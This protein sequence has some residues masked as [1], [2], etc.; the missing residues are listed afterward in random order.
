MST[1][2]T[3]AL[4]ANGLA[5][6]V[7][8]RAFQDVL[9]AGCIHMTEMLASD[10]EGATRLLRVT[11][12]GAADDREARTVARAIVNSPLVK[13]QVLGYYR[14]YRQVERQGEVRELERQW[15]P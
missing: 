9:T 8:G 6:P 14:L 12:R 2:D 7:D 11:V 4:L 15:N 10:G 1:S 5:G 3:C 13:N